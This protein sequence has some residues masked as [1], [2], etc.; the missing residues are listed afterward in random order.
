MTLYLGDNELETLSCI[1][2]GAESKVYQYT[3]DSLLKIFLSN[4]DIDAKREKIELLM[5]LPL[6]VNVVKPEELVYVNGKFAGYKMQYVS[7]ASNLHEVQ[8]QEKLICG[9]RGK[10]IDYF[11]RM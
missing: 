7:N 10:N 1:G 6:P 3:T 4:I 9:G 8:K 2:K 5:R 11:L